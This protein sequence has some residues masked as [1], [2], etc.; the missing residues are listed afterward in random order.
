MCVS[1]AV[2]CSLL[3]AFDKTLE[4]LTSCCSIHE[5]PLTPDAVHAVEGVFT[6]L[7]YSQIIPENAVIFVV[8]VGTFVS[9]K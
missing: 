4:V 9:A 5:L 8:A 2:H 1:V 3:D 7:S 6:L